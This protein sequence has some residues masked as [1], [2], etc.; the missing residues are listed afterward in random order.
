MKIYSSQIV[1]VYK[2]NIIIRRRI[3]D[4]ED[5]LSE[6]FVTPFRQIPVPDEEDPNIPRFETESRKKFSRL[7]VSQVRTNFSTTYSEEYSNDSLKIRTYLKERIELIKQ[8]VTV[9]DIEYCGFILELH[10]P[11]ENNI[12]ELLKQETNLNFINNRMNDFN[13]GY[14]FP[15][16]D[17]YFLNVK[18]NKA[19]LNKLIIDQRTT[20][21]KKSDQLIDGLS[22]IV[23]MN[24]KLTFKDGNP[25]GVDAV[26]LL[27]QMIFDIVDNNNY[28]DYLRGNITN[29]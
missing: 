23:D 3:F 26:N 14:S 24:S 1:F 27:E 5:H 19:K 15:Y 28:S 12:N 6:L 25:L 10:F 16:R 29:D 17:K 18:T 21:L 7:T 4:F 11:I 9:E 22:V 2:R 20:A 13:L 8:I